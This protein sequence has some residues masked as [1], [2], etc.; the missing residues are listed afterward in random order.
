MDKKT[1]EVLKK[2]GITVAGAVTGSAI[3]KK[4][5]DYREKKRRNKLDKI[6]LERDK[7]IRKEDK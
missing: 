4:W 3:G 6:E 2:L 5:S 1:K 7:K